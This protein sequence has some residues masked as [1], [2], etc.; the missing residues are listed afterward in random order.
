MLNSYVVSG[1]RTVVP[2]IIGFLLA[3]FALLH[4]VPS[5]T[6]QAAVSGALA[7]VWY[8][9]ARA[10]EQKWPSAGVLLGYPA[11]PTY[12]TTLK[13]GSVAVPGGTLTV[14]KPAVIAATATV[15]TPAPAPAPAPTTPEPPAA[16]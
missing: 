12:L 10:I 11:A 15:E 4:L 6:A 7:T 13:T 8:L 2:I 1:I 9:I 14:A 3:H 5:A 16:A